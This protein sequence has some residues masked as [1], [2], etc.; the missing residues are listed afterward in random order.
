MPSHRSNRLQILCH[1]ILQQAAL[2]LSIKASFLDTLYISLSTPQYIQCFYDILYTQ[3]S[4]QVTEKQ[5]GF[6][7]NTSIIMDEGQ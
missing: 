4:T 6:I 7:A 5:F 2:S 1:K 3:C